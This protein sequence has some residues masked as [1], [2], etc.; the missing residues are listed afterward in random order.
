MSRRQMLSSSF[1][2]DFVPIGGVEVR[3]EA[4]IDVPRVY[5]GER[6]PIGEGVGPGAVIDI[7][8]ECGFESERVPIGGVGLCE[9]TVGI[10]GEFAIGGIGLCECTVDLYGEFVQ[11]GGIGLC[12]YANDICGETGE[13]GDIS[14]VV[15][16]E[17][18]AD[19]YGE[20]VPIGEGMRFEYA[21]DICGESGGIGE[22][23]LI[24][25]AG[26]IAA[27]SFAGVRHHFRVG[28]RDIEQG[29]R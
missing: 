11:I 21:F 14:G 9:Y 12:E 28:S 5:D 2:V 13:T 15:H 19:I 29:L 22:V 18:A 24:N 4:A 25:K 17:Y 27:D 10:Y 7:L 20:F 1:E 6:V 3:P 26:C 23:M 8:R 16:C